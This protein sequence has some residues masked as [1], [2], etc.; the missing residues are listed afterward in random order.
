M[1]KTAL[2]IHIS[3]FIFFLLFLILV[4]QYC[5]NLLAK[6]LNFGTRVPYACLSEKLLQSVTYDDKYFQSLYVYTF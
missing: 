5:E 1:T 6:S 2:S 4:S 3:N